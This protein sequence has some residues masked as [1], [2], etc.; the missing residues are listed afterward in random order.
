MTDLKLNR[1][2]GRMHWSD[3][4]QLAKSPAHYAYAIDHPRKQ[5]R[6]MRVGSCLDAIVFP[7]VRDF[8]VYEGDR[9]GKAWDTFA[10]RHA[11]VEIFTASEHEDAL[12]AARA[13]LESAE[14]APYLVGQHQPVVQ[15]E[16][17][18]V[19]CAA[20]IEGERGGFD[21]LNDPAHLADLKGTMTSEPDA[22][23]RHSFSMMWHAQ[24]AFYTYGAP[25]VRE[26]VLIA[27]EQEPPHVVSVFRLTPALL[28][29][30]QKTVRLLIERYKA[31]VASGQWPGYVQSAVDLDV[32]AWA[33]N[34]EGDSDG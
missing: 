21:V 14:A 5:T 16:Y 17:E 34:L 30:G 20:G 31:C 22:F 28:L 33:A 9:R 4:K 1:A 27:V 10:E 8:V 11:T 25:H 23:A 2:D 32:P 15:W 24:L 6:A 3:L 12:G 18:G 29:A 7:G 19:P 26:R 13:V